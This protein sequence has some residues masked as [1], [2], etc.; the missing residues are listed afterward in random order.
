MDN[1]T[2]EEYVFHRMVH[3][4]LQYALKLVELSENQIENE[5]KYSIQRDALVTYARP[6][7]FCHGKYGKYKLTPNPNV[8]KEHKEILTWRDKIIAHS[9]I[10]IRDPQLHCWTQPN[11]T[12]PIVFKG[13]Y[14]EN[15]P[16]PSQIKLCCSSHIISVLQYMETV[17]R[18][19]KKILFK[20]D[21][22]IAPNS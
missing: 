12:F 21:S 5:I 22:L 20:E 8:S 19:F 1:K 4:D 6:F 14:S 17:E 13:W 15:M 7:Y 9:D 11:P 2:E 16:S 3:G 18:E 10:D